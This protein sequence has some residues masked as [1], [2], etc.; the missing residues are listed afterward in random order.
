MIGIIGVSIFLLEILNDR[1]LIQHKTIIG[2]YFGI[3]GLLAILTWDQFS[4]RPFEHSL[5]FACAMSIIAT[6]EL[7]NKWLNTPEKSQLTGA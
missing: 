6:R 5:T 1:K 3:F 7:L 2:L 4:F